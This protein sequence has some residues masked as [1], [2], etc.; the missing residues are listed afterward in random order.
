MRF[1]TNKIIHSQVGNV[2]ILQLNNPAALNALDIDMVRFL[3][4]CLPTSAA[5]A[6]TTSSS[7]RPIR[8][9]VVTSTH[10]RR[11]AFCA[12]GDMKRLYLAGRGLLPS[13]PADV[14]AFHN[15]QH[16]YGIPG[17]ETADF[18][19][20]E[21]Q[22]NYTLASRSRYVPQISLWDGI[23]MGGGVG[24]S[25]HGK[26]RVATEHTVFAMPETNIGFF[27]DIGST[28]VLPRLRGGIGNY[29]A[30]TGTRLYANDLLYAGLAT[31]HI[32]SKSLKEL[33]NSIV[34]ACYGKSDD[35]DGEFE[36]DCVAPVL[37]KYHEELDLNQSFLARHRDQIEEAFHEKTCVEDILRTL[38][39]SQTEF[40]ISTLET[41][42]KMSPTSLKITLESMNRGKEMKDLGACLEMEYRMGQVAMRSQSD[43]YEGIRALLVDKDQQPRWNP[44]T[45][46]NVTKEIVESYFQSL[47][48]KD[49]V[50]E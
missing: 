43:F 11:R 42:N 50:L 40:A 39:Q 21:Y 49:L 31:H 38:E 34:Q 10:D 6:A 48:D 14:E 37:M 30:L 12:G 24:V 17:L 27:P 4:D 44:S 46:S 1:T 5:A 22:M 19:R 41:L 35:G 18:F 9:T 25:I 28:Y 13:S 20:G 3:N 26:Y 7:D 23:V 33:V 8:A 36:Q 2:S 32:P 47:G 45:L 29:I 16:G 15:G